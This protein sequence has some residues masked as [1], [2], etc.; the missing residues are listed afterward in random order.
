MST[1]VKQFTRK[2]IDF[3]NNRFMNTS[4]AHLKL[5]RELK[6]LEKFEDEHLKSVVNNMVVSWRETACQQITE[7]LGGSDEGKH[8]FFYNENE[9]DE[10]LESKLRKIII[11]FELIMNSYL[12]EFARQ[13]INDWVNFI[14]SFTIPKYAQDELWDLPAAPLVNIHLAVQK[15]KAKGK[16]PRRKQ[17]VDAEGNPIP[18]DPKEDLEYMSQ[19][20]YSPNL[21]E[22]R[23]FI[24]KALNTIVDSNN[25]MMTLEKDLMP[26]LKLDERP[27]F[28]MDMEFPWVVDAMKEVN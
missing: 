27:N 15:P 2:C 7:K 14:R 20:V 26:F 5:P 13:S 8:N 9:Q 18:H 17:Q 10:Y 4:K 12:R 16:K 23:N 24:R 22:C 11:R 25:R 1:I 28:M 3:Q 21:E 19:I 6:D